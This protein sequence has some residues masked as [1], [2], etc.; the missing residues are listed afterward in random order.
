M[1][2]VYFTDMHTA[3]GSS[4]LDKLR[5]LIDAAGLGG[6]ELNNKYVAIKMHFGEPGNLAYLRPNWAKV[7]ADYV[8]ERGGRP[9]LTDCNTLYVGRRKDALEHLSAAYENGF[10]LP[11][12]G[13]HVLI[14]DGLKGTDE[15]EVPIDGDYV[16]KA[17]I[18]RALYDADV[19]VSLTHFKCHESTGFGGALKN[20]G[21][22]GGSRAGKMEMHSSGKPTVDESKCIGCGRC[23]REC[24]QGAIELRAR[25]AHIDLDRCVGCGRCL[26][27]CNQDAIEPIYDEAFPLLSR[28]IAEYAFAVVKDK[29]AFHVSL[30]IDV[31]PLCDCVPFNDVPL[32]PDVGM[33]ASLDPV[34][35]DAACAD[36]V[37]AVPP[38]AGG[39]AGGGE[40]FAALH[41]DA[42]W[43]DQLSQGEKIGL[44]ERKYRLIRL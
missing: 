6:L 19:I 42:C 16:K 33:F 39:P 44:G 3:G 21:M 41:P 22:G 20:L 29:P 28:K 37:N 5:R 38:L 27:V 9:F 7:V 35:L 36:A 26:G 23:G 17:K 30:V 15:A 4:Q 13:C 14:A 40:L 34:A 25:K 31:S 2:D 11:S 43:Q 8:R 24:A 32:V 18:G 12:A 1:S 10:S